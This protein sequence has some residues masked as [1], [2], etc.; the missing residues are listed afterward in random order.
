MPSTRG[1]TCLS[2]PIPASTTTSIDDKVFVDVVSGNPD[3]AKPLE[4]LESL[5]RLARRVTLMAYARVPP[6]M[7]TS[8]R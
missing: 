3:H 8:W 5:E 1:R 7:S 6:A 2:S 4:S